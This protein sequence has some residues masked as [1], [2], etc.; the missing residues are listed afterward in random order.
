MEY[1]KKIVYQSNY[2]YKRRS[3]KGE[4]PRYVG[5]DHVFAEKSSVQQ[6]EYSR[7]KSSRSRVLIGIGE[8][9]EALGGMDHQQEFK[10]R[11]NIA[12]YYIKK[13]SVV[14]QGA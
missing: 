5:S 12:D 11:D 8:V 6:G 4:D 3:E 13:C 9:P 1:T 10:S 14:R 2:W 7:E